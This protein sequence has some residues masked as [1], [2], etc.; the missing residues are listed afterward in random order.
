MGF[1]SYMKHRL[2]GFLLIVVA[3]MLAVASA[4]ISPLSVL[5]SAPMLAYVLGGLCLLS[6]VASAY[7]LN[8][9][10]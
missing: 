4:S 6:L 7:F 9:T 2:L 3:F 5:S 10:H 1:G 8:T